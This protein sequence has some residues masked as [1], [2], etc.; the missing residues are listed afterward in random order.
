MLPDLPDLL[1]LHHSS[2]RPAA[3]AAWAETLPRSRAAGAAFWEAAA[4]EWSGFD[5]I[6][7]HRFAQ[8][9]RRFRSCR[10]ASLVEHLPDRIRIFRG[11][12]A[13]DALGL[14]WTTDR[15]IAVGFAHG[16]RGIL[17]D[18]PFVYEI[19]V[20]R[21]E[22]AFACNDRQEAEIVLLRVTPEMV[23]EAI[24]NAA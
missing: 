12:D 19:T 9:F 18:D 23:R 20:S 21:Q 8:L 17:H 1:R 16:H 15:R 5:R 4:A 13:G 6:D 10:P 24:R 22:V 2:T 3:F 14:A 11:Q 7:H